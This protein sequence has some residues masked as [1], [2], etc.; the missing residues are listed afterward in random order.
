[1]ELWTLWRA[2]HIEG[3]SC[4]SLFATSHAGVACTD[5]WLLRFR[6]DRAGTNAPTY[7]TGRFRCTRMS[8]FSF[9][10]ELARWFCLAL[11]LAA[12]MSV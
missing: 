6:F 2:G 10:S 11:F 9:I 7:T 12:A 1:M 5:L 4:F 8:C 3:M